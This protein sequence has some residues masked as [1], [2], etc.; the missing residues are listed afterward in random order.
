M[1]IATR[2][3]ASPEIVRGSCVANAASKSAKKARLASERRMNATMQLG[4]ATEEIVLMCVCIPPMRR[5]YSA[6]W[7]VRSKLQVTRHRTV[8]G[9]SAGNAWFAPGGMMESHCFLSTF[10]LSSLIAAAMDVVVAILTKGEQ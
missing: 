2:H 1:A 3:P 5:N 4:P 9:I 8:R 7:S 6:A 10:L